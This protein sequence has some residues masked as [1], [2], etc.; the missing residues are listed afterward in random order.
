MRKK[1]K[2]LEEKSMWL[3]T[4]PTLYFNEWIDCGATAGWSTQVI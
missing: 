1:F 2:K 3:S 4:F